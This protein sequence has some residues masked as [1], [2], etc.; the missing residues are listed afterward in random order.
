VRLIV[1]CKACQHQIEPDLA[2]ITARYG[3]NPSVLDWRE[4]LVVPGASGPA[5][6]DFRRETSGRSLPTREGRSPSAVGAANRRS[7]VQKLGVADLGRTRFD[8]LG[9]LVIILRNATQHIP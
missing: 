4:R 2:E 1:W 3:A 7:P 6:S 9:D 8:I 5:G